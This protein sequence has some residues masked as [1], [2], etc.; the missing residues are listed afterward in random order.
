MPPPSTYRW[1]LA[2][3]VLA[4]GL[5]VGVVTKPLAGV[6]YARHG[7]SLLGLTHAIGLVWVAQWGPAPGEVA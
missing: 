7:A 4:A 1:A 3:R 5:E 2:L 6:A